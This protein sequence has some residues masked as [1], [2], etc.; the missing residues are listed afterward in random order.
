[1]KL[2]FNLWFIIDTVCL[3]LL[4]LTLNSLRVYTDQTEQHSNLGYLH[5]NLF[6]YIIQITD[7]FFVDHKITSQN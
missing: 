2:E 3:V 4:W 7:L 1:M 5:N 6:A